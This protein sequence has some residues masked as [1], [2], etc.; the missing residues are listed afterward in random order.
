MI[1]VYT[2]PFCR[3]CHLAKELLT[4][5]KATFEEIDIATENMSRDDL[6]N[7]TGG[8]TV[9]QIVLH[10]KNIGGFSELA[11][12]DQAGELDELLRNMKDT[13]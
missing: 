12:L 11:A 8:R 2:L 5:K 7:I 9:P 13:E 3:Y 4:N 6:E 10:G 1:K